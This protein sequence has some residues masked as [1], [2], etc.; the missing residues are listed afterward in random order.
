MTLKQQTRFAAF[1][2]I[3]DEERA[4]LRVLREEIA[5]NVEARHRRRAAIERAQLDA[6]FDESWKVG[7]KPLRR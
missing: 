1:S 5:R 6:A 7:V 2:P 4:K 3:A